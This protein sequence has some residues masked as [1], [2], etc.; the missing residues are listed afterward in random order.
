M[1]ATPTSSPPGGVFRPPGSATLTVARGSVAL[2]RRP[3]GDALASEMLR[4]LHARL[5]PRVQ[6]GS[7]SSFPLPDLPQFTLAHLTYPQD[8]VTLEATVGQVDSLIPIQGVEIAALDQHQSRHVAREFQDQPDR[9]IEPP[10]ANPAVRETLAV[11]VAEAAFQRDRPASQPAQAAKRGTGILFGLRSSAPT[12]SAALGARWH[13]LIRSQSVASSPLVYLGVTRSRQMG[14]TYNRLVN[15]R[16][17][18]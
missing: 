5:A 9:G 4:G 13:R 14:F 6:V 8:E 15:A 1:T 17:A 11:A 7:G 10:P 3:L 18:G 12:P 2:A 16:D